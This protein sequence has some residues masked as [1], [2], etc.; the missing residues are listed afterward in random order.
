ML[1][2]RD[3]GLLT[4]RRRAALML[5]IG[6]GAVLF[7]LPET[8]RAEDS[9]AAP[10]EPERE[11]QKIEEITVVTTRSP[12]EAFSVPQM[13]S[14]L[15]KDLIDDRLASSIGEIFRGVPGVQFGGGPRRTGEVPSIRGLSGAGVLILFDGARQSFVSGHDGRFFIDP[16]LLAG[17]EVVKGPSSVL[18][19]SGALGGVIAFETLS[20][21]DLLADG[22][23]WGYQTKTSFQG[24]NDEAL[25]GG[26]AFGRVGNLD[27]IGNFTYRNGGDIELGNGAGLEADDDISSGFFKAGWQLTPELHWETNFVRFKNDA[28]EPNVGDFGSEADEGNPLVDKDITNNTVQSRIR[29]DP[30][31]DWVDLE[32]LGYFTDSEV[33]EDELAGPRVVS[34][35]VETIGFRAENQSQ[36]GLG[37]TAQ[38]TFTYGG[39]YYEDDQTGFDSETPDNSRGGVPDATTEFFGVFAQAE[40]D[41]ETP[42]GRLLFVP[43]VRFDDF[44]NSA[45]GEF[46]RSEDAVSPKFALSYEPTEWSL[47]FV[48]YAE[49]FRAPNFNEVFADGIHFRVPL[50]P[51]QTATNFFVPNP[52]LEPENSDTIEFGGGFDFEDVFGRGDAFQVK[53]SYF[54]SDVENLIDLEVNVAFSPGCFVP[55]AGPCTAGTSRNI[56]TSEAELE[57]VELEARYDSRRVFARASFSTLDGRNK[58][59]GEFVGVLSPDTFYIDAG[60]RIPEIDLRIGSRAEIASALDEVN[61]PELRLGAFEK[62][63]LYAVWE[64][65]QEFLKGVRVD[66]ALDNVGDESFERVAPGAI[67]PGRNVQ[68]ALRYGQ[69]F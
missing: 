9:S 65:S 54:N 7:V 41:W 44:E 55:G 5:G 10:S 69:R 12:R 4:A 62:V 26:T 58:Q 15:D 61:D 42:V 51:F 37:D 48:N 29:F 16:D 24:V 53:A 33:E 43:G 35:E 45:V 19:G 3:Y 57:G 49:A 21:S 46:E 27:L 56:N 39:E 52:D 6:L 1:E 25:V 13:V 18:Y 34:R 40:L 67:A 36:F 22:E 47:L 38:V 60:L 68:V 50:G 20:A 23:S 59:T 66:V 17:A 28:R 14:V 11:R 64:P 31:T 32:L 2:W 30:A 63:D 8:V